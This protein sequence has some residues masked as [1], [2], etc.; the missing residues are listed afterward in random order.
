VLGWNGAATALENK[1][2][3]T[4][5]LPS[6]T[7]AGSML[8]VNTGL[9][10]Y[11][12]RTP[13]QVR[14][15]I[16]AAASGANN[17]ITSLLLGDGSAATPSLSF[18]ADTN[19]GFYR[20]AA[21]TIGASVNGAEVYRV[22]S[23][24]FQIGSTTNTERFCV[25]GAIRS[26]SAAANFNSGL[27]G[28]LMDYTGTVARF[29]HVN[30]ASGSAKTVQLLSGG[31]PVFSWDNAGNACVILPTGSIGYTTGA[32]GTVTQATSKSTAVTLNKPCGQITMNNAA[33]GA[34]ASVTFIVNNSLVT[35][36]DIV[37]VQLNGNVAASSAYRVE[38]E[39][40]ASGLFRVR[41]TNISGGSLSE[42]LLLNF[43]VIKGTTS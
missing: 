42:A 1:V 2:A 32:G 16:S 33:L 39:N 9:T 7:P 6:P 29:G 14:G 22:S 25:A 28:A 26:S 18:S 17:D 41:I 31:N 40:T 15:D 34:G 11:E 35:N 38:N 8:R 3:A 36:T 37:V 12:L 5:Y 4:S 43:S 23:S 30:G 24:T 27:E 20:I 21:D 13:T 10:G 19:T